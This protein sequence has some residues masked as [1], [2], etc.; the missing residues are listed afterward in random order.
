LALL[1]ALIPVLS[2]RRANKLTHWWRV[3]YASA[4]RVS[5]K[6]R[7][8]VRF[9]CRTQVLGEISADVV[10]R[11][12][13]GLNQARLVPARSM[14]SRARRRNASR[15]FFLE[16]D[17]IVMTFERPIP[18]TGPMRAQTFHLA[19]GDAGTAQTI[20]A[21]QQLIEQGKKDPRI[22]ELAA[23][24]IAHCPP[25]YLPAGEIAAAQAI[26]NWP[27]A[28]VRYTPDVDG[29]ETLHSAWDIVRLGI[30]DCDDFTILYCSLFATI[31]KKTRIVTIA[32][33]AED[34]RQFSHVYPEV[35]V[36]GR[37]I[38]IDAARRSA[39][40]AKGPEHWYRRQEWSSS[41]GGYSDVAGMNGYT[42]RHAM[43]YQPAALPA[44]Y[45]TD[46]NPIIRRA[47]TQL[48][49]RAP[50]GVGNYGLGALR[51]LGQD[52]SSDGVDWSG[53][54]SAISA[55]TTGTANIITAERASPYNL[56][57]TTSLNAAGRAPV[58]PYGMVP[59]AVPGSPYAGAFPTSIF[60]TI[61]PTTLLLLGLGGV[62][63]I[64]LASRR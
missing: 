48:R 14:P 17:S 24:I 4:E 37:W 38:P 32:S 20:R 62:A 10:P 30:G 6:Y 49:G 41:P 36:Q 35:Y 50:M 28:H 1:L 47:V 22:H 39:A 23:R 64:A 53:I 59:G 54:A 56:F 52:S 46:A 13:A 60:S 27:L 25:E 7:T 16:A 11:D 2:A 29:K 21:M 43:G 8:R 40:F 3:V 58:Y 9:E 19:D 33:H 45:R 51:R 31:G 34:P 63:V 15:P 44:A 61:S 18:M 55:G 57:P 26:F 5:T 12:V 42:Q